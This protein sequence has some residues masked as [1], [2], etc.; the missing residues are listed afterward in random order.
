ML[1]ERDTGAA[2]LTQLRANNDEGMRPGKVSPRIPGAATAGIG[3][4]TEHRKAPPIDPRGKRN[5]HPYFKP[6]DL[7]AQNIIYLGFCDICFVNKGT[8]I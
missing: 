3:G 2:W 4:H 1:G 7:E 8:Q 5:V 6:G